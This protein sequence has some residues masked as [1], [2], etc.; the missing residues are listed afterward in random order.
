MTG[1]PL[2]HGYVPPPARVVWMLITIPQPF[3]LSA[4]FLAAY[5][6]DCGMGRHVDTLPPPR[7]RRFLQD[8]YAMYHTYDFAVGLSRMSALF[9]YRRVFGT[10]SRTFVINFWTCL[11]ANAAW[12]V[13][14]SFVALFNCVPVNAFWD[15]ALPGYDGY[16]CI[17][18]MNLQLGHGVTSVVIDL[19]LLLIPMPFVLKLQMT[20]RKKLL[21]VMV[22]VFA[23][24]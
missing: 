4:L 22:F 15:R 23:Y 13:I 7:F 21:T 6:R 18:T 1:L 10:T 3:I 11:A 12:L 14:M 20:T 2:R 5:S 24:W 9:F 19:W 8:L 17:G 16:T